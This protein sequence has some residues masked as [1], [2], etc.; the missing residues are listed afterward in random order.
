MSSR[1][2]SGEVILRGFICDFMS[3]YYEVEESHIRS[4]LK[5]SPLCSC[6]YLSSHSPYYIFGN[7]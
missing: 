4:N 2:L 7:I 1:D 5:T 6:F 3:G